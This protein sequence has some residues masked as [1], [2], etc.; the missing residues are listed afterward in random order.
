MVCA[1]G[2]RDCGLM[3]FEDQEV[4]LAVGFGEVVAG[5][6]FEAGGF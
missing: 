1:E 3:L 5:Y 4:I 6:L 2:E